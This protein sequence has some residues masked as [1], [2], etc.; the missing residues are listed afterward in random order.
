MKQMK[1][2]ILSL[3]V[4]AVMFLSCKENTQ[5]TDTTMDS[6]TNEAEAATTEVI[7]NAAPE[8]DTTAAK[9]EGAVDAVKEEV[10]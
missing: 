9:V 10:K 2:I 7:D 5:N 3:A 6:A 1:K 8:M 4:V